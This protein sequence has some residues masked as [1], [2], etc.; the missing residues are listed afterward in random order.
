MKTKDRS[1]DWREIRRLRAGELHQQNWKQNRT[2]EALGVS[3]GAVCQW[4]KSAREGGVEALRAHP[5]SGRPPRLTLEQQ[6]QLPE[7]LSRGAETY[8]FRGDIWTCVR[9]AEIIRR[10]FGVTYHPDHVSRLLRACGW[11]QQKPRRQASQRDEEAIAAWVKD[12][13]PQV[14]KKP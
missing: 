4:L 2:A 12:D 9:V 13:W 14:K 1:T 10:E 6:A 5:A 3:P 8:G 11:S 7:L